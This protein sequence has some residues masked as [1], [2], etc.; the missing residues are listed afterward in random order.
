MACCK[1]KCFKVFGAEFQVFHTVPSGRYL[2]IR[3][4]QRLDCI[5]A[6]VHHGGFHKGAFVLGRSSSSLTAI[7]SPGDTLHVKSSVS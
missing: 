3:R 7:I 5:A 1:F 2:V 4:A 6:Y